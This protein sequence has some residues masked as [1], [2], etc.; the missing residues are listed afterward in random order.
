MR[1]LSLSF[2]A[3][4]LTTPA[5]A[6]HITVQQPVFENFGV[7]TAVTVPD[8]GSVYLGGVNS[9][10]AGRSSFGFPRT[11]TSTGVETRGSSVQVGV[12]IHNLQEVDA[13]LLASVPQAPPQTPWEK[14]LAERR[15]G[16]FVGVPA[17]AGPE[18]EIRPAK[19]GTPTK[20]P[21]RMA[22]LESR[23]LR[24]EQSGKPAVA[25]TYWR[26]AAKE[27]SALAREKL[28][29]TSSVAAK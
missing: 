26:M 9:A 14:R 17:S 6:Q 20:T 27:G 4:L 3:L 25:L 22:D 12:F 11:S 19:A 10:A 7:Q 1:W 21:P 23:A 29:K 28:A 18:E 24:A 5:V 2:A 16:V 13:A 15:V 8:R